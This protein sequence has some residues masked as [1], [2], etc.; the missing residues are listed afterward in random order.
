MFKIIALVAAIAGGATY[1]LYAHTN[2]LGKK[3]DG[4]CPLANRSCCDGA[5][6]ESPSTESPNT[7]SA[8]A[9]SPS[10]CVIPCPA[11]SAGCEKCCDIC[12][13]CCSGAQAVSAGAAGAAGAKPEA[14]CSV[15]ASTKVSAKKA[16]CC[17][18]PCPLCAVA[19]EECCPACPVVCGACCGVSAKAAVAGPAAAVV[20]GVTKK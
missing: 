13:L 14:C 7:G 12:E 2:L 5:S 20:A 4:S 3:C 17:A 11:C 15:K 6:T 1:G 18:D 10:C 19:C 8:S 16:G 9:A